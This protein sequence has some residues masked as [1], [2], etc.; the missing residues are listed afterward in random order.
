MRDGKRHN[1]ERVRLCV[2]VARKGLNYEMVRQGQPP[3]GVEERLAGTLERLPALVTQAIED[4]R[5][6][7]AVQQ[8]DQGKEL[9]GLLVERIVLQ[10]KDGYLEVEV[11]GSLQGL[12]KLKSP[13]S[14]NQGLREITL[15]A[16]AGFEPATFGL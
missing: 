6:L 2:A 9:L 8:I 15:V 5:A 3:K 12:L 14:G 7:L 1:S 13:R 10:P 16:G 4:L 11:R